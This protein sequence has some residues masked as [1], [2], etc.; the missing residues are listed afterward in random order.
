MVKCYV[1]NYEFLEDF[2]K[3]LYLPFF[4]KLNI[5]EPQFK[6]LKDS[7][8][9]YMKVELLS[10]YHS[11]GSDALMIPL[12]STQDYKWMKR[13]FLPSTAVRE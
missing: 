8:Y 2:G 4:E 13:V 5:C 6:L 3:M 1:K 9:Q 10:K 7:F 12:A 11:S